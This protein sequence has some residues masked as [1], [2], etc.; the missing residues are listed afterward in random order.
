L[1]SG[2][3]IRN[4]DDKNNSVGKICGKKP[5]NPIKFNVFCGVSW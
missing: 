2:E 1:F 4:S 3:K 5:L